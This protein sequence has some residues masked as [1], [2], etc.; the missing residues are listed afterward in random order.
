MLNPIYI[1][2]GKGYFEDFEKIDFRKLIE[3]VDKYGKLNFGSINRTKEYLVRRTNAF[4]SNMN[5]VDST[6]TMK[7]KTSITQIDKLTKALQC[8]NRKKGK[9]SAYTLVIIYV[10]AVIMLEAPVSAEYSFTHMRKVIKKVTTIIQDYAYD[11]PRDQLAVY[12][13]DCYTIVMTAINERNTDV[14]PQIF[15]DIRKHYIT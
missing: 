1:R 9:I 7:P 13:L 2:L 12:L 8:E 14:S 5:R 11:S 15:P 4:I 10:M 3:D 6:I